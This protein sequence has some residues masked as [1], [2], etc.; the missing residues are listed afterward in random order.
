MS[1]AFKTTVFVDSATADTKKITALDVSRF[2]P[3][4]RIQR[5]LR[6]VRFDDG[7]IVTSPTI[8]AEK[9]TAE[10]LLHIETDTGYILE[11]TPDTL[12]CNIS[13]VFVPAS[14]LSIGS[15]LWVNGQPSQSYKDIDFLKEWYVKRGKTQK[16]I[17]EMCSTPEYP[18]SERTV[19]AYVKRYGLGRGDA[20]QTFGSDNAR[21]KGEDV[22]LKGL[23]ERARFNLV[24]KNV[25][26]MCG[27]EGNTDIHHKDHDLTNDDPSN[28]IE[29]CEKCHQ[30]MHKG[31]MIRHIRHTKITSIRPAGADPTISIS[32]DMGNYVAEGFIVKNDKAYPVQEKTKFE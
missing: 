19:R 11:C 23:Y 18:V 7:A 6:A 5:P 8:D 4:T 31:A 20:G 30:A 14:S 13:K 26:D 29:L 22:T 12:I 25:C 3:S 15:E 24:K 1:V 17:A 21:Y 10:R 2:A 27:A 9:R 16:E 28:L 32:T